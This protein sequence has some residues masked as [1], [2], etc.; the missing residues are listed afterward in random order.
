[1][2]T[3]S[4]PKVNI[5][6]A[7][8]ST[9]IGVDEQRV[10]IVGQQSTS[11]SYETGQLI[12]DIGNSNQEINVIGKG[13]PL[14]NMLSAFK[15]INEITKVDAIPLDDNGSGVNANGT[16]AFTG[17]ATANG[18]LNVYISSKKDNS[19]EI[20][21][22]NGNTA[23]DIGD[24]LVSAITADNLSLVSAV[25]TSGSVALTA[26]NAGSFGNGI[27]IK[28]AGNVA[29]VTPSV[30][31]MSG[32]S[33][34]PVLTSL[35]NVVG[36]KRYQHIVFPGEYD[37]TVLTDF[38]DPRWNINDMSLQ[39][40]GFIGKTDTLSNLK[41]FLNAK[42]SQSLSVFCNEPVN[43]SL[44]KGNAVFEHNDIITTECVAIFALRVTEGADI[45]R[46]V[47]ASN[48]DAIG[49]VELSTL[50]YHNTP[51]FD[52]HIIDTGKGWID[53]EISELNEA[54]G[55][56][57]GNNTARNT[58]IIDKVV[59]TYKTDVAGNA[60]P[61]FKT[62]NNV[63][64]FSA[65][66]NYFFSNFKADTAQSRL[67]SG[68]IFPGRNYQNKNTLTALFKQYYVA[69]SELSLTREGLDDTAIFVNSLNIALDLSQGKVT[70]TAKVPIVGQLRA[71]NFVMELVI[72]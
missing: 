5:I 52:L 40:V 49:G 69:T 6:K 36:N 30:T 70:A 56:V 67:T 48:L 45:S 14:G 8:A 43:D 32:G 19:Y 59:T 1:M 42:N 7:P 15:R 57:V 62:L 3:V 71:L 51:L 28:V 16:I 64:A 25:N 50:P 66:A 18:T 46:Y 21:V 17:T 44:Y 61:S 54:G 4:Q 24:A 26:K 41:T 58:V 35:F 27:G 13:S 2:T 47:I 72:E 29:G 39:G 37:D 22:K 65:V 31:A 33:T 53:S 55:F 11:S 34:D 68:D 60:D 9:T 38:L 12:E 10:L 23:T 20:A 63:V